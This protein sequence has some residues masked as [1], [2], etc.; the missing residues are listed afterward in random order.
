MTDKIAISNSELSAWARCPRKWFITYYLG[1]RPAD[2]PVTSSML[3]GSRI[4]TA[5]EARYGHGLDAL[6]VL[7]LLYQIEIPEHPEHERDLLGEMDLALI[8][9]SG[10]LDWAAE[11]G[12]DADYEVIAAEQD[13]RTDLPGL[14]GV[15]LRAKLDQVRRRVSDGALIFKDWKTSATFDRHETLALDPQMRLYCLIQQL[16]VRDGDHP[17]VVA[18]GRIT[19][20]RRCKRT[21]ASKPPYYQADD[22][23]YNPEQID[24]TYRRTLQLCREIMA[25]REGLG[26]VYARGGL[27][28]QVNWFQREYLRPVP[29]L[30]D[31]SWSCPLAK[32]ECVAMDDGSD[33]NGILSNSGKWVQGDPYLYYAED[34]IR[35]IRARLL[36]ST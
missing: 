27:V 33:W 35:T 32:G 14:P 8:M 11:T 29:I 16:M 4:H 12:E 23:S 5:L 13:V 25:A 28:E 36:E 31:C 21:S 22:F 24:S 9:V 10:Y 17:P 26:E 2:E 6:D 15:M 30:T 1:F 7:R 19:T 20:L 34:P 3:L 18:G